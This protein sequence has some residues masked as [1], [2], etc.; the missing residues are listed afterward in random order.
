MF[1]LN[2]SPQC[3]AVKK[4]LTGGGLLILFLALGNAGAQEFDFNRENFLV[5]PE[6]TVATC[7]DCVGELFLRMSEPEIADGRASIGVLLRA[8]LSSSFTAIPYLGNY[9]FNVAVGGVGIELASTSCNFTVASGVQSTYNPVPLAVGSASPLSLTVNQVAPGFGLGLPSTDTHYRLSTDGFSQFGTFS[10]P[11]S[12]T[13]GVN[14]YIMAPLDVYGFEVQVGPANG[15]KLLL[16]ADNSY[17]YYPLDG[18]AP[19]VAATGDPVDS[20]TVT[21][22]L[23]SNL[24]GVPS[25]ARNF[26]FSPG[27]GV[28]PDSSVAPVVPD[29]SITTTVT[30]IKIS[31]GEPQIYNDCVVTY[32]VVVPGNSYSLTQRLGE[33][34]IPPGGDV[35]STVVVSLNVGSS[36]PIQVIDLEAPNLVY[37]AYANVRTTSPDPLSV[38]AAYSLDG[39]DIDGASLGDEV[40]VQFSDWNKEINLTEVFNAAREAAI[41]SMSG[42]N[43]VQILTL[44]VRVGRVGDS[45]P[46][47]KSYLV[48]SKTAVADGMAVYRDLLNTVITSTEGIVGEIVGEEEVDAGFFLAELL[49]RS[50]GAAVIV[51]QEVIQGELNAEVE[52]LINLPVSGFSSTQN[53]VLITDAY[54]FSGSLDNLGVTEA[55]FVIDL[56]DRQLTSPTRLAKQIRTGG[57]YEQWRGVDNGSGGSVSY[58]TVVN[59]LGA[60]AQP[61]CPE[62][63]DAVGWMNT[64]NGVLPAASPLADQ[65][66][67]IRITIADD[68]IYDVD[69]ADLGQPGLSGF[70][71]DPIAGVA[72][73]PDIVLAH[74]PQPQGCSYKPGYF[75]AGPDDPMPNRSACVGSVT[76]QMRNFRSTDQ[77][78]EDSMGRAV[79]DIWLK[80]DLP[81]THSRFL[82]DF[83]FD[84]AVDGAKYGGGDGGA[85]TDSGIDLRD[86]V[87]AFSYA[88]GVLGGS[89]NIDTRTFEPVL[90]LAVSADA[91]EGGNQVGPTTNYVLKMDFEHFGTFTCPILDRSLD[92]GY[93]FGANKVFEFR[94]HDEKTN[95]VGDFDPLVLRADNSYRY[96]PLDGDA[97]FVAT[98]DPVDSST[99]TVRLT[100]NLVGVPST[101]RNFTFSPGCGVAPDSSVAPVVPDVSITLL[102]TEIPIV[103][104]KSQI[105][106]DCVV[107][108]DVVVPGN[109]YSLTQRLGETP[110]PPGGDVVSTVVVSLNVGSS[111]PIQVI[112]L[113]AP[114]LV[115]SAYANVRTTS[116][117]PLSVSAAYSLDGED[118]DGASLGDEVTVQFSDWNKEINLT[119]VFNAAR[120]A[121]IGSM[122]GANPVQILTL[123]VRVGRVGDSEPWSKSY[124]VVSKTAVAD[125]MAVYRDLLNTVI[126]STE[127]I[128][129]EIVG[130]E[131]VDAGFFLAELLSR[132]TGAA[133]IV[134]QE[135][136]QGELNAEVERLIN[137]PVS[138]FSS[139]QNKVLITDAYTFSGSLDNL[140]VTEAS[141]VIDLGDR[142][143]TSPTR[144]AKQIRTGGEYEQWR[145]VDNGSGGSVSYSTVVNLLGA[146]AQP[147]CPE[148]A[149]AVGWMN[150]DNGVLPA[151]SPLADQIRCIRITIAD[152]GIYD[153]DGADLG[154]PGLSGFISDPI[155]GVA[156][157]PDIVLAHAPQPQG[158]SY[159]PGYFLAGP[160]DPMPNRSA[161]VGSVTAQMRNFRS[162]DQSTEDSMGRAVVDIWLKTDLPSTHSRFLGDF[163][164]DIAV[165]GAKYGGGDGGAPTDSGIDLRDNV[166]AFSYAEG[167]LGGSTNID[168]R[169]F[170]P[171]LSLAVS[172][173]AP[174]G[175]NQVGPTT[176]Y[177]LKMDF[178]HFGT[179]TCPILDR[180]LDRGYVFGA[181]KVF[182]FRVHDEKTN[183]V[184]DFDPLVLRADNSYRYYPLDGDAPFVATG[185]PVDSSTVTV[186]L[187][188]NLV[189]VPS[190]ARNFTFSPGC[191][192]APVVPDVPITTTVTDI[193]I[194]FGEPQIYN[195]CVVTYDV[196]VPGNSYSLTQRLGETPIPPGGDVVSTVVVSL[197]VGSSSPIQVIDLEAPNLV[198]SA[199]ANVRTTSPDPLSV[200]AAYSLDGEDIDGASLGDEVTVQ[201]SDWNKKIDLTEVFNA[202]REAAIGSMSGANPVQ[203]LTLEVRVGDSEPSWSKSYLVVSK[204]AV[205]DGMAVY[206]DLLN[207]VIT[208]T[209]G[210][211]GEIVG[212]EEVDAGFFLAELL[213]RS[214][215]AAVI[216]GQEAIQGELND[217]VGRLINLPESGFSSTQNKVLITDA[218]TF[219]G[220]LD[221]LGVTEA[222]FVID[223]GSS[224]LMSPTRLAKQIR[225]G[226]EQ[227][228]GV[229]NGSGGSVSYSANRYLLGAPPCLPANAK[230]GWLDTDNG[231]GLLPASSTAP[232]RCI[233]ITIADDGIYDVDGAD[234][235]QPRLSGF[236]SDPI[237]GVEDSPDIVLAHAGGGGGGVGG[238]GGGSDGWIVA[239]AVLGGLLFAGS[240]GLWM[241]FALLA[242]LALSLWRRRSEVVAHHRS[243]F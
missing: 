188:S 198:Y 205:A 180:S 170:E 213:S 237:A 225:T 105:Y 73:S 191:G 90:S 228:R 19:F 185:D 23:T 18:D 230:S 208:S 240:A 33:T 108:Y 163:E 154:Q 149:D 50:T 21:V 99:V 223:L 68:G 140:G 115:Y 243:E 145:G 129:G 218:Y 207:T 229:D 151:A 10:C 65:I 67:C 38:S 39:E 15:R 35:V 179:F 58:S 64:D 83:E 197:N 219:S 29:V 36:S 54:T 42:A 171:V 96:Y 75:L 86:N 120:E 93:V 103:F 94:V 22:S 98:G 153:V 47:S 152:D 51:G 214:T 14:A 55:S 116:P 147:P 148:A 193:K 212:E 173:D 137:L 204:T 2:F 4:C 112:D 70:I 17:R 81:S 232:I 78:T 106:N 119:E 123:E 158:C 167:V 226:V 222:S 1:S 194:S 134:G 24:V 61:P 202:A 11:I 234:L 62:A 57:E 209:E 87:C 91:P 40:T 210:I 166:C 239:L 132:S 114:N 7:S 231:N 184:G 104:A 102:D 92:R 150:T 131:E 176:N 85:P 84:I 182:E 20:S 46:W 164:F 26:T 97:P 216:V 199:Y 101:A 242:I 100:S 221:N 175:G 224:Q 141:F 235:G 107:T 69:G 76:A 53:K 89:T 12:D 37:S 156:D 31:F 118:I 25:T 9:V 48:V 133:V 109:S 110:I 215:G 192:V 59:L 71:S 161:C 236:I 138:G 122:S 146:G 190:T 174:E 82:G 63:A 143:L 6:P 125:G 28:A 206:R 220:S 172:A 111:S 168:T 211:V 201:F 126:T 181:N 74:A 186:R 169:T 8:T 178:E 189:G 135:V 217:E 49:S 5:P 16:R 80:T 27:C 52:R 139:T 128:V 165:D 79:V 72:D 41:G 66:R 177:V 162:T 56:G 187:T 32:D 200:S 45:E 3:K 195:D 117:D 43:P 44:E 77:S 127:G 155:A 241:I 124:L 30:D 203:I 88:E 196:V 159:K 142:Q 113:E 130:E 95:S 136:I 144:L 160:D 13:S 227:W 233:R 60:G 238:G 121:A 34:P 157:S 183:S